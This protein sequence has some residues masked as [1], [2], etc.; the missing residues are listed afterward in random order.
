MRV[1]KLILSVALMLACPAIAEVPLDPGST[2][3][4]RLSP[5]GALAYPVAPRPP[6]A[7]ANFGAILSIEIDEP[8]VY[9]AALGAPGWIDVFRDGQPLPAKDHRHGPPGSGVAKIVDYD[10]A[11]GHYTVALS[12]MTEGEAS[13][14]LSR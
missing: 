9:H 4:V 2:A 12:G 11:T 1:G 6:H 8:G 10:L 13:I 14:T 7:P 3:T 5:Q